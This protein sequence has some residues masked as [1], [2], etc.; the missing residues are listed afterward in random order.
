MRVPSEI[1]EHVVRRVAIVVAALH[2]GRAWA[3]ECFED[4]LVY[5]LR[6]AS[7]MSTQADA[8]VADVAGAGWSENAAGPESLAAV[9][10]NHPAIDGS[11]TAEVAHFVVMLVAENG[12]PALPFNRKRATL[13]HIDPFTVGH[14]PGC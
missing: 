10:A 11:H 14:A 9:L 1:R 7:T 6:H 4:E 13:G 12:K 2:T 5:T 8:L 3:H